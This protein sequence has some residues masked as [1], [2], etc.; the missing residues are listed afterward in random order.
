MSPLEINLDGLQERAALGYA[1]QGWPAL[2]LH[3]PDAEGRCSCGNA[4]CES[5]GKH[6]RGS[7]GVYDATTDPEVIRRWWATWPDANVGLACGHAFAVE[8][9]DG[10]GGYAIH[11]E[12][13]GDHEQP[14]TLTVLT[15]RGEHRYYATNGSAPDGWEIKRPPDSLGL[16]SRGS[17]VVAPPSRH[18]S[19][20]IYQ[21]LGESPVTE[22]PGWLV[23]TAREPTA[24]TA[25]AAPQDPDRLRTVGLAALDAELA[26]LAAH[27]TAPGTGRHTALFSCSCALHR[28]VGAESLSGAEAMSALRRGADLLG[29]PWD[30]ETIHQVE[31][32]RAKGLAEPYVLTDRSNGAVQPGG[33][34][35]GG[36]PLGITTTTS[37]EAQDGADDPRR[38]DM[39]HLLAQPPREVPWRNRDLT[40]DGKVT[41]LAGQGGDGKSWV[42]QALA[43]GV[44]E[45]T[46][47]AGIACTKG[48]GLL[49][50]A[51]AGKDE[52]VR[53]FRLA[54]T[55]AEAIAVYDADGL[56]IVRDQAYFRAV[57][58]RERPQLVI[59]DSLRTLAS[60]ADE[61]S[62]RD[63][64]PIMGALRRMA[65]SLEVAVLLIH[66]RGKGDPPYRGSS[67][68]R[69]QTDLMF[70]L[71]RERGDPERATRR[72]LEPV[73]FRAG[74]EPARRWLNIDTDDQGRMVVSTA[75]AYMAGSG[76]SVRDS[77]RE[78]LVDLLGGDYHPRAW[79]AKELGKHPQ[80]QLVGELLSE[81]TA[82]GVAHHRQG[83]GWRR[84]SGQTHLHLIPPD[85]PQETA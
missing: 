9:I 54:A 30:A 41:T 83:K 76:N 69:D 23:K 11:A 79:Y 75:E 74:R 85:G 55:P 56:H 19:G 80:N 12:L 32:G 46:E 81:L 29:L 18:Y 72:Y 51:E 53:R 28:H 48:R 40:A 8:D 20:H 42:A 27:G 59:F 68:I 78:A 67:V 82:A 35:G 52:V 34:G 43:Q 37:Q 3:T 44:Y 62:S 50:D 31:S 49:F 16:R 64:E 39:A 4:A 77:L 13:Q 24:P 6:P 36:A 14:Q 10:P 26:Q 57:I 70:M 2:A 60:G 15:S 61:D 38:L 21:W 25:P 63:M 1:R 17:I 71:A 7:L 33:R 58:E 22:R 84:A 73:K 66:H 47:V 65:R 5:P 45:G